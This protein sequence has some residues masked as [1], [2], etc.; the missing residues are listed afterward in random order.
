MAETDLARLKA[1]DWLAWT[2][3]MKRRCDVLDAMIAEK[4]AA[5][6]AVAAANAWDAIA[7]LEALGVPEPDLHWRAGVIATRVWLLAIVSELDGGEL[8]EHAGAELDRMISE[9]WAVQPTPDL[10]R[11]PLFYL[12][13]TPFGEWMMWLYARRYADII[14]AARRAR[15]F[16]PVRV[17]SADVEEARLTL[18]CT[19]ESYA[20]MRN[21]AKWVLRPS[22]AEELHALRTSTQHRKAI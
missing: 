2:R 13:D 6:A 15:R 18:G 4:E 17:T 20:R 19:A 11:K 14:F 16:G 9:R 8:L 21:R 1:T 3:Y 22:A 7:D 12:A 5:E 10:E